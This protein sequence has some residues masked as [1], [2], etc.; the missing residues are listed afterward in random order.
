M[1]KNEKKWRKLYKL[2]REGK[3]EGVE[4]NVNYIA[5]ERQKKVIGR[6]KQWGIN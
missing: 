5:E 2:W 4:S 6:R 3:R 1:P